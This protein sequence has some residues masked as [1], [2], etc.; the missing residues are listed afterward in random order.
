M[1]HP[2]RRLPAPADWPGGRSIVDQVCLDIPPHVYDDE[3]AFWRALTGWDLVDS[4]APEL[5]RLRRPEGLPLAVILQR[6]DE[7]QSTTTAHLDLS[8]DDREAETG[9]HV[10]LGAVVVDVR[11]G[12]TVLRDPAGRAYCITGRRP[13]DV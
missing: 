12:W 3:V 1:G 5:E 9:R 6:L 11:P 2:A 10:S 13:G 4:Q 7:E 8:A